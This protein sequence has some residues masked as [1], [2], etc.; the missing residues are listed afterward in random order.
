VVFIGALLRN[1]DA[2]APV[3]GP[4]GFYFARVFLIKLDL[5]HL[6]TLVKIH[7]LARKS[8]GEAWAS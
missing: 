4:A 3:F 8:A 7:S 1:C 5:A 2:P 6:H